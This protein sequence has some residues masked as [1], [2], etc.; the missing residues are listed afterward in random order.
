MAERNER[1]TSPDAATAAGKVLNDPQATK[2]DKK[3]AG[4]ALSQ[5]PSRDDDD[6]R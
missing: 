6:R 2:E 1:Q 5:T 4:S 3:A